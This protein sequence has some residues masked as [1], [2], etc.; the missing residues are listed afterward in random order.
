[1][2]STR[3][4]YGEFL[5]EIGKDEDVVVFDAD[6]AEATYTKMFKEK[7]PLRHIDV[8]ISEQDM[9]CEACGMSLT[10]KKVFAS[11]FAMFLCGRAYEQIRNTAAYSNVNINLCATHT[12]LA[13]GEDGASHQ[14]LEDIA[15][16]RAIPNMKVFCPADDISTKKILSEC[17][18]LDGPK[19]VRLGRSDVYDIYSNES[20]FKLGGS[21][22]F[23]EGCGGTIF[24]CGTTVKI[25]LDAKEEL[26]KKN[27]NVR[28]VDIY[29]IKPIDRETIIK[30]AKETDKLISIEDH[31]VI[32]G[33]GSAIS[34]VL[35]DEF[36]KK[37]VRIGIK[38]KFGKSGK[39]N[40]LYEMYGI[41]K[42]DIIKEF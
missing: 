2:K 41:T 40:E 36:P 1:M 37:L 38:D 39:P 14:M 11:S 8:G 18:K 7:Y 4:A 24:A 42:E 13:V 16:M 12:G 25:A 22:T 5:C 21:N 29:S 15:L 35:T 34:E 20:S 6:L 10:G 17:L 31:N 23:G 3:K 9:V 28:V 30:C 32:G 27:I 19:Y 26:K 33:I